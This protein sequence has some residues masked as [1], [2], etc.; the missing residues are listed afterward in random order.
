MK[1]DEHARQNRETSSAFLCLCGIGATS[2]GILF[3]AWGYIHRDNAAPLLNA[4][5]EVLRYFVPL[6]FFVGLS[7]LC[8]PS[9]RPSE[10]LGRVGLVLGLA[11]AAWGVALG[12]VN[13]PSLWGYLASRGWYPRP[14]FWW[15]PTLLAG[16]FLTGIGSVKNRKSRGYGVLLT[17]TGTSGWVYYITDPSYGVLDVHLGHD[18]FGVLFSLGWIILGGKLWKHGS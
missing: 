4:T 6:L 14:F 1:Q 5:A 18:V 9:T 13:G 12:F 10:W 2:A 15:L 7:G 16:L 3:A 11:G 8:F 17:A